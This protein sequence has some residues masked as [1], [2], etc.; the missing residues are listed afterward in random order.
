MPS[1][2]RAWRALVP[3]TWNSSKASRHPDGAMSTPSELTIR[4]SLN[5]YSAAWR[6]LT[7]RGSRANAGIV[8]PETTLTVSWAN[9]RPS[10][11]VRPVLLELADAGDVAPAADPDAD[12]VD[13][14]AAEDR[15]EPVAGLL[16]LQGL[17]HQ[18][19]VIGRHG[20]AALVAQEVR[21]VE[22]VDVEGVA[23]DPLAAVEEAAERPRLR[24]D[25]DPEQVLEPVD[26]AHLVGDRTDAADAGDD[27]DDLVGRSPH[28]ELLEVARRLEDARGVPRRPRRPGPAGGASPS[29]STR[30]SSWTS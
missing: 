18:R 14:P 6:R 25:A 1:R 24:V 27:V 20:D 2:D 10:S 26:R 9:A 21:R 15:D 11:S 23:F 22:E 13:G 7:R 5:G 17:L 29:P 19:P 3:S 8:K 4:P 16:H 12:R 30:V 28:D